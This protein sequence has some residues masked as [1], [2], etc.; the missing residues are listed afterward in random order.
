MK[1][2][3]TASDLPESDIKTCYLFDDHALIQATEIF[4][5]TMLL[6]IIHSVTH[7]FENNTTLHLVD[8]TF[9]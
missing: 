4:M 9:D 1:E 2:I 3:E 5:E 7:Y 8:L 6:L